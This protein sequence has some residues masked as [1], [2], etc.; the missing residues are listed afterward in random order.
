L[1]VASA[2]AGATQAAGVAAERLIDRDTTTATTVG[3]SVDLSL[4]LERAGWVSHVKVFGAA[5]GTISVLAETG[6]GWDPIPGLTAVP[7][8]GLP[9]GWNELAAPQPVFTTRV[10]IRWIAGD[11]GP[12]RSLSEV[13]LWGPVPPVDR[14]VAS[15]AFHPDLRSLAVSTAE[16]AVDEHEIAVPLDLATA[17]TPYRRIFLCYELRGWQEWVSVSRSINGEPVSETAFSDATSTWTPQIEEINPAWLRPGANTVRF[18]ASSAVSLPYEVRNVRLVGEVDTGRN[19]VDSL[20]DVALQSAGPAGTERVVTMM[21]DGATE[22]SG[23]DLLLT[24]EVSASPR[25]EALVDDGWETIFAPSTAR[26]LTAGWNFLP[27]SERRPVLGVR[28][29]WQDA[30]GGASLQALVPVGSAVGPVSAHPSLRVTYPTDGRFQGRE[31]Y[32]RGFLAPFD[33]GSGNAAIWIAGKRVDDADGSFSVTVSKDDLGRFEDADSDPWAVEVRA[34]FPNGKV[35]V[36]EVVLDSG[37]PGP[38]STEGRLLPARSLRVEPGARKRMTHDAATLDVDSGSVDSAIDVSIT[39]LGDEDLAALDQGMTN[40]T[41]GPRRGYRFQPHGTRFKKPIRVEL[42]YD[43]QR[44]PAGLTESDVHTFYFDDQAGRWMRLE[45]TEVDTASRKIVSTTDHFTDMINATIA[46]PEHPSPLSYNPNS[47][48]D[49]KAADPAQK[50]NLIEAPEANSKGDARVSYPIEVPPGRLGMAPQLSLR[51]DSSKENGWLGLGWELAVP[52]VVVDTRWGVPRYCS[53]TSSA[54]QCPDGAVE[55]ETY[56]LDGDQLS[57]VA[58]RAPFQA[59]TAEKA[60]RTRVEGEFRKIVRHGDH[61]SNYTWEVTDRSGKRSIFGGPS[62]TLADANGSRFLW[63]LTEVRDLNGNGMKYEYDLVADTGVPG[64]TVDGYQLYLKRIN[65]TQR[66]GAPGAYTI[67]FLRDSELPGYVRRSDVMMDARGGFKMVTAELLQRIVVD[68]NDGASVTRVRSYDLTYAHGAFEKTLLETVTQRG[69]KEQ[70]FHTH[71]FTYYDDVR[72][73]G[74]YV[75]FRAAEGWSTGAD[76]VRLPLIDDVASPLGS[77]DGKATALSGYESESIG[78]HLYLGFNPDAPTKQGSGGFKVGNG[79]TVA[80]E[81]LLSMVD[82]NGDALPDKVF[83]KDGQVYFRANRSGPHGTTQFGPAVAVA[84]LPAMGREST[85]TTSYGAEAYFVG[86]AMVNEALSFTSTS[87][88]FADANGDGLTDLIDNGTVLFNRLDPDGTPTFS[89]DSATSPVPVTSTA[90]DGTGLLP[91]YGPLQQQALANS[92]LHDTLRR[93]IAPFPGT[94][95]VTGDVT[96]HPPDP[97]YRTADGV[98][99]AIQKNGTELWGTTID[100]AD[101]TAKT[102]TG[103]DSIPVAKGDRIYFRIHSRFDGRHDEVDWDPAIAYLGAP[104]TTDVNLLEPRRF[105]ASEDFT[106]AGRRDIDVELPFTGRVRLSGALHKPGATTDDVTLLIRKSGVLLMP[107]TTKA[108]DQTGEIPVDLTFDVAQGERLKLRVKVDS[109]ID[110]RQIEWSPSLHY[111]DTPLPTQT[112]GGVT[113]SITRVFDAAG[114]PIIR[115]D[116]PYDIDAYSEDTLF[117]PQAPYVAP[118]TGAISVRTRLQAASTANGTIVLTAKKRGVLLTKRL[119]PIVGGVVGNAGFDLDVDEDDQIF[120]DYSCL[121]PDLAPKVFHRVVE[122]L[123]SGPDFETAPSAF[124]HSILQGGVFPQ[125]YRGWAVA[126]YKGDPPRGEQPIAEGDLSVE[127][128]AS[129][130]H[131]TR[132]AKAFLFA[133]APAQNRWVGPEDQTF[134]APDRAG[135]SRLGVDFVG[136]PT[137]TGAAGAGAP[138]RVSSSNQTA[139]GGGASFLSGSASSGFGTSDLDYVDMNGDQFPDVVGSGRMQF[140]SILGGLEAANRPVAG[141]DTPRKTLSD[142]LN[143]GVGGSPAEFKFDGRGRVDS[144]NRGPAAKE[145]DTGSQMV[146]LGLGVSGSLGAGTSHAAFDLADLNSDGLPDRVTTDGGQLRVALNLGYSFATPELW[147]AATLNEGESTNFSV[148]PTLGFNAGIYD[149]AGGLSYDKNESKVPRDLVDVNGDGL[150]DRLTVSGSVLRVGINTGTGFLPDVTWSGAPSAEFAT[151]ASASLG[152]GAYFTVGIG[153]LC[154][155]GCYVIINPG[156]DGGTS[157]ARQERSLTDVDGDGFLDHV[158][159]SRDDSFSAALNA[160]G[161][162]NLLRRIERPLSAVIDLDY[163]REGNTYDQPQSRWVLS[164]VVVNDGFPGDGVD[165]LR[166]FKYENG[167]RDRLEREFYGFGTVIEEQRDPSAG[168]AIYRRI[169]RGFGN[170]DFYTKGLLLRE[171]TRDGAGRPFTETVNTYTLRD[172]PSGS[173]PAD[174]ASTTATEF[175]QLARVDKRYFEGQAAPGKATSM[176]YA[177]DAHGNVAR[178]VDAGDDGPADDLDATIA[179]SDCAATHVFE[180]VALQVQGAGRAMRRRE[181][182]VDCASGDVTQVREF[183][184]NGTVAT[185]DLAYFPEGNL[186]ELTGPPNHRNQR[187][188]LRYT[189]DAIAA[190]HIASIVDSYGLS[191]TATHDLLF[192]RPSVTTDVAGNVTSYVYDTFGRSSSITGP[193]EQ[194]TGSKT[195]RFEYHPEAAVPW[196]RTRH[197]DPFR[198]ATDTIDT[199]LFTDGLTRVIQIKKDASVHQGAASTAADVMIVSGRVAF[200]A[201]GRTTSKRYSTVEALVAPGVFNPTLDPVTPTTTAYDVL[202][203]ITEVKIPDGARTASA[204]GFGQDRQGRTQ[205]QTLVTDANGIAKRT[206]T[207]VREL[208]VALKESNRGGAE[209]IWTSYDYDPMKQITGITDDRGN[210]THIEYDNLG[211]RTV[212]DNP[213]TGRVETI[214]DLAA[215][216]IARVTPNLRARAKRIEFEHDFLRVTAIRYPDFPENNVTYA[217]GLPGAAE[218]AAGRP[219]RVIDES[220]VTERGYGKLGELVRETKTVASETQ[221]NGPNSPEIYTTRWVYD[222]F[223]RLQNLTYPDGELL[224]Y[225][226]DSGG[227]VRRA[228]G[229]KGP[230]AYAYVNR[231]EYDKFEESVFVEAGNGV[232]TT[233]TYRPDNRRLD[234]L[235]A[236]LP[237]GRVVQ[238]LHYSYDAVGNV[239][240]LQNVVGV[241]PASTYGGPTDTAFQYDDLYR[242]TLSNGVHQFAPSKSQ[243]FSLAMDYDTIHNILTKAQSDVIVQPSQTTVPQQ[244]TSYA[245]TYAYGGPQPHAPTHLGERTYAYDANGNQI[246]FTNDRNGTRRTIVWDEENRIQSIADNGH[247]E[248]YKYDD[249]GDRVIKRG[250]QGETVYV[251]NYFTIR[252]REVGTKHVFIGETRLVSKMMKQNSYEKDLYFYHPDHIGSSNYVTDANAGLYE[253]LEYF[254]FGEAWIEESSNTQRTP[255]QFT[256]KELDEETGLL[257]F[258]ARYFDPRTNVWQSADPLLARYLPDAGEAADGLAGM[259]GVFD[260][261]N[262]SLYTYGGLNP[263]RVTDLDGRSKRDV[264]RIVKAIHRTMNKAWADGFKKDGTVEERGGV[265]LAAGKKVLVRKAEGESGSIHFDMNVEKDEKLVGTFHTHPYS[266][267]ERGHKAVTFSGQDIDNMGDG[268]QGSY[269]FI[270]AGTRRYAIEV[271]DMKKFQDFAKNSDIKQIWQ[272]GFDKARSKKGFV[273]ANLAG[274]KAVVRSK[275]SG[276]K[277]YMSV[278]KAKTKFV[279]IK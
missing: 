205:F 269:K 28:V 18:T 63:A 237:S 224:T 39:P 75:G 99:V 234:S 66:N 243:R 126:G 136:A 200:D 246:G 219:V 14:F 64:G 259:G 106:M 56:L 277:F 149:Y 187:Y 158:T 183:L 12:R 138:N 276:L 111:L 225:L 157:L 49:I 37:R 115:L 38:E 198:S 150:L 141:F 174:P 19:F 34:G 214:Y 192:G 82:L 210:V 97:T 92:P 242:L 91:D 250:P 221:G 123:D 140:S 13:E 239:L 226:Y 154:V 120:F 185:T 54:A 20:D 165:Q 164:K 117:A 110:L 199:V 30:T 258:G 167:V 78:A 59:R 71:R 61:P 268:S 233:H 151:N 215:N 168:D 33:N 72:Q 203:R 87:V 68:F 17:L 190:T 102:P 69:T 238:N 278:D 107:A 142:A 146:T 124:R 65:Y 160:T 119:I 253:H 130:T 172:E 109:P 251:N 94:V 162:T 11:S 272:D 57:P 252:N 36:R 240:R 9:Q 169:E 212:I 274:V 24:Q 159:S 43:P 161:R 231:V 3:A 201:F 42:P 132:T 217:F 133:P 257:Y 181:A 114:N 137:A 248:T 265:I 26:E 8:S 35:V 16:L 236:V 148:G 209:T 230:N 62:A 112:L 273:L 77:N 118:L 44:I 207:D 271:T 79:G 179:Y 90:V 188:T 208:I 29:A 55:T 1:T 45:R 113:R 23:L 180:A 227:M 178:F 186:R 5:D 220:G 104:S 95:R 218:N 89:P 196:A 31:A 195:I 244:K 80:S 93:W 139:A 41:R 127:F 173:Q 197:L 184:Q 228:S 143:L 270:E 182:A 213:D 76:D 177:Y 263:L 86:N 74:A 121:D 254:P 155:I 193:Y 176:S 6:S 249:Q 256:S 275:D 222:T 7:L 194:G 171:I 266:R 267:S 152:A 21:L 189:Y 134:A 204:Y 255:Y 2:T 88:Y 144:P 32:L 53:T 40:V 108:W 84:T 147:G 245:W 163:Q 229:V 96:L 241:P 223:G 235:L 145:N 73:A 4:Q 10:L 156:A 83:R 260:P 166:T 101:G 70:A 22:V 175:P 125:P 47:I 103:V 58:H 153:P 129:S 216:T 202:D 52:T 122:V 105:R 85:F 46:L 264:E 206:L 211:R 67:T 247:T 170:T 262:L 128:T 191:S 60:F 100:A 279:E 27:L 48:K 116:P 81:A 232:R 135:S 25:I 15:D 50:V 131:D 98:R 51:Y 261:N